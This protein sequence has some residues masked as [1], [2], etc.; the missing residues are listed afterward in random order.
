M[1][2]KTQEIIDQTFE[3]FGSKLPPHLEQELKTGILNMI[4]KGAAPKDVVGITN[5]F[6]EF[7]YKYGYNLFQAGKYVMAAKVFEALSLLDPSDTRFNLGA[8]A[9]YHQLGDFNGAAACYALFKANDPWKQ[10]NKH[11]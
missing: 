2:S 1:T 7:G 9:C 10:S 4:E 6:V 8:A 5:E 11:N 3:Q